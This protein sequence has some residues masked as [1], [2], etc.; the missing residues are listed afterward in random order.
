VRELER[1]LEATKQ[2]LESVIEEQQ[3]TTEELKSA[4]EEVQSSN[5]ELQSTN[6]ELLTAKEELQSANEE[7][8]TV[9]EEMSNRNMELTHVNNDL[10][11]LL[12][13]VNIPIVMLGNDLRLRRFT[14]QA[15]KVLSLIPSDVGRHVGD[16]RPKIDVQDLEA[17]LM[18]AIEHLRVSEREVQDRDGRWYTLWV[19]PYRT[20]DNRIDGAVMVLVDI[21]ERKEASAARYR[22]LFEAAK[23]GILL[24]SGEDGAVI[25]LNPFLLKTFG[26]S[27]RE[28]V[29]RRY[30]ELPS[31]RGSELNENSFRELLESETFFR[32]TVLRNATGDPL[33]VEALANVYPEGGRPVIQL[34]IRDV[35]ERNRLTERARRVAIQTHDTAAAAVAGPL[36]RGL[37]HEFNN[38]LTAIVG[39]AELLGTE[40]AAEEGLR[41][42]IARFATASERVS[43][44][45]RYL[46]SFGGKRARMPEV[47]D[48]NRV[49]AG[50]E[51][52]LWTTVTG[53][54]ELAISPDPEPVL[55][56]ADRGQMEQII[57]QLAMNAR[58][59]MPNGGR[60]RI[61]TSRS[62]ID[63]VFSS[64]HPVVPP[65]T[66][67]CLSVSQTHSRDG[68]VVRVEEY[69]PA[70]ASLKDG[71][72]GGSLSAIQ[73]LVRQNQG[74]MWAVSE[75]GRGTTVRIYLPPAPSSATV[76]DI[77]K[78]AA[79]PTGTET[80]LLVEEDT[81]VRS[82][83]CRV[84]QRAGYQVIE[85]GGG[86]EAQRLTSSWQGPIHV[87]LT[88][89]SSPR[90]DG[91]RLAEKIS[92]LRP[93]IVV[94]Y[95]SSQPDEI[96]AGGPDAGMHVIR[97]PFAAGVLM[98]RLREVLAGDSE[99]TAPGREGGQANA[100]KT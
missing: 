32:S 10:N 67:I 64:E 18:D 92:A 4:N 63:E 86:D 26:I 31:V 65:G 30:W 98:R 40:A 89:F 33:E 88:E 34:N 56:R 60:L 44:L 78:W 54:I 47:L 9:N 24:A 11:N 50:L 68:G 37:A 19:R 49:L 3:A 17:L 97:K 21:T 43:A 41:E 2:Y 20:S 62:E 38:L 96:R 55:V 8:T 35:T 51:Q 95:T 79:A 48:L 57:V 15:E 46:S 85:A 1:E 70:V 87:L 75:L 28:A 90:V 13:S 84:L 53:S 73:D 7:L 69:D 100:T 83:L 94:L 91:C 23:D 77:G 25:D 5:E 80:V 81:L 99:E 52:I 93:N 42:E 76:E 66:Y 71:A 27:R 12:A 45:A 36:G 72:G 16:F 22:R 82:L 61:G 14:P 59:T 39:Y 58:N 6:E 74:H 29:G